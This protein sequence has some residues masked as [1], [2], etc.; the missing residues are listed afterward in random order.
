VKL[1]K[2]PMELL[3]LL[4]E[5][6]GQ[7]VTREEIVQRLWGQDVFVDT[8]NG[9][10]TAI[11]KL[12]SALRDDSE[13]PRI[14]ETVVG[15]GYRLIAATLGKSVSRANG[16][17]QKPRSSEG[18]LRGQ[19]RATSRLKIIDSIAVLP[20]INLTG[21]DEN[22]YFA[23][24]LTELIIE[25]LSQLPHVRVMARSTV[26][27]YKGSQIDPLTAGSELQ[28]RAVIAGQVRKRGDLINLGL[29]LVDVRD[30]SQ[31]WSCRY[32]RNCSNIFDMQDQIAGDIAEELRLQL[33]K[34]DKRPFGKAHTRNKDA[35][36]GYL[37]GR[38]HL[39]RRTELSLKK[40][41]ECFQMAIELDPEY[42]QAHA[43]LTEAY[44][45]AEYCSLV[46]PSIAF[47][48]AKKSIEQAVELDESSAEAYTALGIVRSFH[49]YDPHHGERAFIRALELSP[50]CSN[51]WHRYGVP[52]LTSLRRFGEA[53]TALRRALE[54]DPFSPLINAH[55]GLVLTY[56]K[57]F[58]AAE[59]QFF[60]ALE[61]DPDFA[62]THSFIGQMYWWSGQTKEAEDYLHKGL[63]LSVGN[64]RMRC[65]LAG[66]YAATGREVQARN[67]LNDLLRRADARYVSPVF[68]SLIYLGFGD[69]EKAWQMLETA[70]RERNPVLPVLNAW[71]SCDHLRSDPRFQKLFKAFL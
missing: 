11:H 19:P 57:Q 49:E 40:S 22:E 2:S 14:L 43:G 25:S 62:E 8:R 61:M 67:E 46:P 48:E 55:L 38:F 68:L 56:R 7:L 59:K 63:D 64:L 39:A 27:R 24:G 4:V 21:M 3:I 37:M 60:K 44:L 54:I 42:S 23:D 45:S 10:N 15:K 33:T 69:N 52:H 20:L 6:R 17:D 71:P 41:L 16:R 26:F 32:D 65:V 5:K 31:L 12:R 36:Q 70:Y 35:Y 18:D 58:S 47:P 30:G 50:K 51:A 9:I 34:D 53:E 66:I 1:E 13:Q 28:V 29:E